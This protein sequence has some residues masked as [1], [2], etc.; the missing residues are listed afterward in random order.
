MMP[1]NSLAEC[2]AANSLWVEDG[3]YMRVRDISLAYTFT[4]AALKGLKIASL[5]LYV[6]GQNLIT[7]TDY[8]G[9]DPESSW[10][11]G[12]ITP[13]ITG[14]DRGMYPATKSITGG[15]RLGF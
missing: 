2:L 10:D 11:Q 6:S 1:Q 12:N 8:S 14:W 5:E 4:P 9:Y 7:L 15:V 3:S 13:R